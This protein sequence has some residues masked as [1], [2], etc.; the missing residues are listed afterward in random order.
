MMLSVVTSYERSTTLKMHLQSLLAAAYLVP[1][2]LGCA[3]HT[4]YKRSEL[5]SRQVNPT[6]P[7]AN[8]TRNDWAYEASVREI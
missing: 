3:Q 5:K 8:T 4:N 7:G 2:V 1:S 6:E